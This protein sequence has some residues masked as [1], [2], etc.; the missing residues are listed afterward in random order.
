MTLPQPK[1]GK[2]R[3]TIRLDDDVL[4]WFRE[5]ALAV[6]G[7]NYQTLINRALR[8]YVQDYEQPLEE[9]LRRVI[10]EEFSEVRAAQPAPITYKTNTRLP[11]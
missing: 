2:T 6:D 9:I 1:N 8:Q 5:H 10:R 7:D 11:R 4:D 3:I